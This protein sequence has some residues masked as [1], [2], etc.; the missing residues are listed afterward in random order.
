MR[1]EEV[2]LREL[3]AHDELVAAFARGELSWE[4]FDRA[5]NSFYPRYPL[6][7][8]ESDAQELLLFEK[9]KARIA[10]H[11]EIWDVMTKITSDEHLGTQSTV[12]A[13]FIGTAEAVSRIRELAAKHLK[14]WEK[15]EPG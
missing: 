10:L 2:L 7:G 11:H 8:H 14:V 13:G 3:D 9:H 1:T 15:P 12:D 6:D 4:Q 5:Y